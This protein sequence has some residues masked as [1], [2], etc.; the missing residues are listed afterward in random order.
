MR[1]FPSF[2]SAVKRIVGSIGHKPVSV[3]GTGAPKADIPGMVSSAETAFYSE[4][5]ARYFGREGAIVDLGCWLGSTSIALAQGILSQGSKA[6]NRNE[7]VFGFDTFQWETWMPAHIPYC[8][9]EPGDSFLP[10]ARRLV[11]EHGGGRV[12]LIQ[13]DLELY[14]WSGGPIKLLLVDA[15]KNETLAIQIP[16]AFFPSLI[17]GSLLIHQDF[18]HYYTS[19]IH[20][21]QYRLRQYFRFYQSV[22]W[23]TAA[24]E[25]LAPIPREAIDRATEFTTIPDDET[26]ASFRH[27]LDLVG[28]DERANIAAAHV[29]HYLHLKRKDRASQTMELYRPLGILDQGEFPKMLSLL[30]Q[31]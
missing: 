13:A 14:E 11:R 31:T 4:S 29:M 27:S 15:I 3:S 30:C 1:K 2:T 21:L 17:P 26:D 25:L 16:R 7:K 24:F 19:W 28:P 6:D 22:P 18:K 10:E 23:G 20:V 8:Q 12:E 5:A 9:Y